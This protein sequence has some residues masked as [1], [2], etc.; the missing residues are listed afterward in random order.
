MITELIRFEAEVC[1]CNGNQLELQEECVS[2]MR[3]ILLNFHRSLSVSVMEI[4]FLWQHN[5]VS[6]IGSS[7]LQK[8]HIC[9]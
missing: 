4:K 8:K 7:C 6:V 5:S 1:I 2:F 9:L 3:D